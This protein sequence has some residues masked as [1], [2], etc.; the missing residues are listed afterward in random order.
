MLLS[1]SNM[2]RHRPL[3]SLFVLSAY[4][5]TVGWGHV[6]NLC[7]GSDGH[8]AIEYSWLGCP[9]EDAP[10]T[11]APQG[12]SN[13]GQNVAEAIASGDPCIDICL[14]NAGFSSDTETSKL[15]TL[16]ALAL[17]ALLFFILFLDP[18]RRHSS[19]LPR[20]TRLNGTLLHLRTVVLLN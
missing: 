7:I 16:A 13:G 12:F 18:P 6:T 9:D 2:H 19:S 10:R 15:K 1:T 3:I 17:I 8:V 11:K 14:T 20:A 4:L 5:L